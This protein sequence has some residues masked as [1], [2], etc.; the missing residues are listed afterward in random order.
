MQMEWHL[1]A[2]NFKVLAYGSKTI[3][4]EASDFEINNLKAF[5]TQYPQ[6][7]NWVVCLDVNCEDGVRC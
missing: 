5:R 7:R 4:V 2:L 3:L 1:V 6:G